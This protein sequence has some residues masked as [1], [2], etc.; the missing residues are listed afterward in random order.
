VVTWGSKKCRN[1]QVALNLSALI[2]FCA[3]SASPTSFR[4]SAYP[5][6]VGDSSLEW[7]VCK[8]HEA[9]VRKF[10]VDRTASQVPSIQTNWKLPAGGLHRSGYSLRGSS[11]SICEVDCIG[12]FESIDRNFEVIEI[13]GKIIRLVLI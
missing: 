3:S 5:S 10:N 6:M 9:G 1:L 13:R 12:V 11:P 2:D 7:T 4:R 8:Y